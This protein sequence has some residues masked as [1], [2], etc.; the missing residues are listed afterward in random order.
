MPADFFI[1]TTR[2]IVFSKATG[3][4]GPAEAVEHTRRLQAHPEFRPELNQL[5]DFREATKVALS[6][7]DIKSLAQKNVFSPTSQRVFVVS[8]DL[9]FG[10]AR[11]FGSYRDMNGES[12]IMIFKEMP[13]AL[14]WLSLKSEPD[15]K[16][17][18]RLV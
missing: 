8:R 5:Y 2:G 10:I 12:G 7:D 3:I 11:A 13:E 17:F 4:F 9:D 18:E 16:L 6:H 14:A 15:G 1:D